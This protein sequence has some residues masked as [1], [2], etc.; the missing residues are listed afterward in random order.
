MADTPARVVPLSR[1]R[2]WTW[3][4]VAVA[5]VFAGWHVYGITVAPERPFFWIGVVFYIEFSTGC[6]TDDAVPALRDDFT[7]LAAALGVR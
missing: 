7:K 6:V 3:A 1:A 5:T 4:L 2:R